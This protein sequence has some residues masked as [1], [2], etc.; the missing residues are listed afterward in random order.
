MIFF[1]LILIN[2]LICLNYIF[3]PKI[4]CFINEFEINHK[5]QGRDQN[6]DKMK[7]HKI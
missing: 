6:K 4:N 7:I 2:L 3:P 1:K 5:I